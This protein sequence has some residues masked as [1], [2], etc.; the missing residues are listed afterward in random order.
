MSEAATPESGVPSGR[1]SFS[2]SVVAGIMFMDGEPM[3]WATN[4]EAGCR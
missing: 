1:I 3:N 2:P 4:T